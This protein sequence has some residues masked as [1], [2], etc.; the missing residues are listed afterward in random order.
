MALHLVRHGSA[1]DRDEW[2]GPDADRPLTDKGRRQA[3]ALADRFV[4]AG[5]QRVLSSRY[6][7]CVQTVEPLADRLGLAVE[8]HPALAEEARVPDLLALLEELAH[9]EV[10]VCTHGNLIP[11]VLDRLAR[12]GAVLVADRPACAKGSVWT[13]HPD[14]DRVFDRAVYTPPLSR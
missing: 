9:E 1:G 5:V 12:R 7:R 6:A 4:D 14:G 3:D 10:A 2:D 11:S 8:R 13:L